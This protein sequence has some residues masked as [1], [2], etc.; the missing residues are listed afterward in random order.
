MTQ[1][2][3]STPGAHLA[4]PSN[5]LCRVL[6]YGMGPKNGIIVRLR[7]KPLLG[8]CPHPALQTAA[9]FDSPSPSPAP[10]A[11]AGATPRSPAHHSCAL[12]QRELD[13]VGVSRASP[14]LPRLQNPP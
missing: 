13:P 4:S 1:V 2:L 11:H 5:A 8:V 10:G 12:T 14:A 9:A 6:F 7:A 3:R